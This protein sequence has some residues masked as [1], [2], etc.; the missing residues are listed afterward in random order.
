MGGGQKGLGRTGRKAALQQPLAASF[1]C[2]CVFCAFRSSFSTCEGLDGVDCNGSCRAWMQKRQRLRQEEANQNGPSW[3][4]YFHKTLCSPPLR[5]CL[6]CTCVHC[7]QCARCPSKERIEEE[8]SSLQATE[9]FR[10]LP[11]TS[12]LKAAAVRKRLLG[13]DLSRPN[14]A[15]GYPYLSSWFESL[16]LKPWIRSTLTD[17]RT[18]QWRRSKQGTIIQSPY[19]V[20]S[21]VCESF[22]WL[23]KMAIP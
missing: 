4:I 23:D 6:Q 22:Y 7:V 12:V 18:E 19:A 2:A 15:Q 21:W 16:L 13:F 10:G 3:R 14:Y 1:W 9:E 5:K 20:Y 11:T 8:G 17:R